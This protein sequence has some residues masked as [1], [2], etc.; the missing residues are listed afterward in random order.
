[1]R[2]GLYHQPTEQTVKKLMAN[3][4]AVLGNPLVGAVVDR[5]RI[6]FGRENLFDFPSKLNTL[7]HRLA[8]VVKTFVV[9]WAGID[10]YM[11]SAYS[12]EMFCI[13]S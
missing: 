10:M 5:A 13:R 9:F 8:G 1:M 2:W 4:D 6:E 11:D 12:Y 7:V 3:T